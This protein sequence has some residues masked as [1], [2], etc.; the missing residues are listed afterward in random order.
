MGPPASG[1]HVVVRVMVEPV[2]LAA[3]ELAAAIEP[4][5]GD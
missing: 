4:A 5:A 1:C 3:A 2:E